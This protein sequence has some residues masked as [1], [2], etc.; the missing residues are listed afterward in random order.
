MTVVEI[1][2]QLRSGFVPRTVIC[3]VAAGFLIMCVLG[4][5][6]ARQDLHKNFVRFTQWIGPE[7]KYYPTVNEMMAIVRTKAK[8]DKILVVIGGNSVFRGVGQPAD[9]LWSKRL[10]E[11]LGDA[12]CVVNFA[13]NGS[14]ITDGAAVLAEAL[15][16][17][18]PKQIYMANAAP[19]QWP[20]PDGTNTYRFVYWD[21]HYKGLL[22]KDPVRTAAINQFHKV[23]PY[24]NGME[25]LARHEWLDHWFYFQDFW[26]DVTL[27]KYNT[28]WGFYMPG[29]TKFLRPR[30][31]YPDPEPDFLTMPMSSRYIE[32]NLEAEMINVRGCSVYAFNKDAAGKWQPYLP[33]W[34]QFS[35][36][37]KATFPDQLKKRTLIVMSRNSP[38]YIRRLPAD[39]Q[40]RDDLAYLYAV[41]KWKE[42]GFDAIDYGKDFTIDD[43]GDRTHLTWHGGVKL[44]VIIADKVREM[45]R[46]LGYLDSK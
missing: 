33:S 29:L 18:Y 2:R 6:A 21:A 15:R 25:E 16:D 8:P 37:I 3:G 44:S 19:T 35:A 43:Y 34:D 23:P 30:K 32:A 1:F 31:S 22:I 41:Q 36:N 20:I 14:G 5:Q 46:K 11:N 40:E 9:H 42:G 7:T 38:Y 12:Y 13:F 45:S 27:T 26:N 39:E 4:R 24:A 28:V 17:E 10:Q